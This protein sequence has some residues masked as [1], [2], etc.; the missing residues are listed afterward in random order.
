MS[1]NFELIAERREEAGTG[2]SRRLRRAGKVPAILY[3][4]GKPPVKLALN[5]DQVFHNLENEAF[6]SSIITVTTDGGSEQAILREVQMHPFKPQVLHVDLQRISAAEKI[7]I[8]VP[9]HF[10]GE[11][12][13]PAVKEQGGIINRLMTEVEISC[14]PTQLPEYLEV[15]LSGLRLHESA[16]LSDI[17]LP[18]GVEIPSLA[19][20]GED[21]AVATAVV[22]RA[23]AEEEEAEAPA[24]AAETPEAAEPASAP[25]EE[26]SD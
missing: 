8:K 18:E 25:E 11:S 23:A 12:A 19:H 13:A 10:V 15:D 2:A 16:H 24:E 5:Q 3:G 17:R 6:H 4:G 14:L 22:V 20:G 21:L 7:R 1:M 26:D 9:L